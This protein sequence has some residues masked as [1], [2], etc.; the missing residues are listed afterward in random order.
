MGRPRIHPDTPIS[1][2]D[3]VEYKIRLTPMQS[4][5]LSR[6]QDTDGLPKVEHVRRALDSYLDMIEAKYKIADSPAPE[7]PA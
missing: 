2:T 1:T 6:V 7:S 3:Y 4:R 5:R